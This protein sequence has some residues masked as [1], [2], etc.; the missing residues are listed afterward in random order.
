[1]LN[2]PDFYKY[3]SSIYGRFLFRWVD[4]SKIKLLEKEFNG[5]SNNKS[6]IIL[7]LGCGTGKLGVKISDRN[8]KTYFCDIEK[9]FLE[10]IRKMGFQTIL[11]DLSNNLP[12]KDNC[13]DGIILSDVIEHIINPNNLIHECY[14]VLK[15]NGKL[16]IFTPSHD[17][18]RWRIAEK[19][20]NILTKS[21]SGHIT[22]FTYDLLNEVLGDCFE[23]YII[24]RL[25]FGL[26]ICGIAIK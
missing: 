14:R 26:T 3:Y 7:D 2:Q 8:Y 11:L 5:L 20:H 24:K 25:N 19:I 18:Y 6:K 1:M 12:I 17:K 16:I 10:N 9:R 15:K 13:I 21:N 4:Y 22:P 23:R